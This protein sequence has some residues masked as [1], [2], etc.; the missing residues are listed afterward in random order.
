MNLRVWRIAQVLAILQLLTAI[1]LHGVYTSQ[2]WPSASDQVATLLDWAVFVAAI[3]F[4]LLPISAVLGLLR[5]RRWGFYPLIA[6]PLVAMVF[7]TIPVPF[8]SLLFTSN[9]ELMSVLIVAVDL[10]LV[11]VGIGLLRH[12]AS[13][14][15]AR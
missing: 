5:Y 9:I 15:N 2:W 3:L 13:T 1:A 14:P 7:G 10:F 12:A 8:A 4:I 6:F 11:A